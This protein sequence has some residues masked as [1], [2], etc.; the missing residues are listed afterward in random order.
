[1]PEKKPKLLVGARL[2]FRDGTPDILVY[3]T[4]RA[5]YG[6][7]CRLLSEGKLR[8]EKGE[9][10]LFRRSRSNG[11]RACCLP[12]CRRS[13]SA[14]KRKR[15]LE[16]LTQIARGRVW[17]AAAMLYRGDDKRRLRKLQRMARKPRAALAVNDVLYHAPSGANCRMSS[18]ASASM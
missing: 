4:D 13:A 12:S 14:T 10:D 8:A 1:L 18:P 17:L 2:V 11:R 6:R 15:C 5:A 3:P 7:L 16:K 9:C